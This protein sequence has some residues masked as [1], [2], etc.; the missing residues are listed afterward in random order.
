MKFLILFVILL[1]S[2]SCDRVL[3]T[4]SQLK[5]EGNAFVE[6][7]LNAFRDEAVSPGGQLKGFFKPLLTKIQRNDRHLKTLD[8]IIS[9]LFNYNFEMIRRTAGNLNRMPDLMS[10]LDLKLFYFKQQTELLSLVLE[11]PIKW[12]EERIPSTEKL[13][14][15]KLKDIQGDLKSSREYMELI[16]T[17]ITEGK[18]KI[19]KLFDDEGNYNDSIYETK[20]NAIKNVIKR[21]KDQVKDR[22]LTKFSKEAVKKIK[23]L[24]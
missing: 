12:I 5:Q 6:F 24:M 18:E 16:A 20:G 21:L 19:Q 9:K 8:G 15:G 23:E 10:K 2:V 4:P 22:D 3:K 17:Q 14:A 1:V 11:F 7:E 13:T